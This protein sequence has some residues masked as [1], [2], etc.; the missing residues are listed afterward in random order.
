MLVDQY[1]NALLRDA[2]LADAVWELW[3]A[4]VITDSEAEQVCPLTAR[5]LPFA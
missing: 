3:D 2:V 5:K 1:V 4:G